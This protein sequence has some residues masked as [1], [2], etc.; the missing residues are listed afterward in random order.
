MASFY[1]VDKELW[2]REMHEV[3]PFLLQWCQSLDAEDLKN[4]LAI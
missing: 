4:E 3:S 1:T 2:V